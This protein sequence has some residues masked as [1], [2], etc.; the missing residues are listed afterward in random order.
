M[1]LLKNAD[2][3]LQTAAQR[4]RRPHVLRRSEDDVCGAPQSCA[5]LRSRPCGGASGLSALVAGEPSTRARPDRRARRGDLRARRGPHSARWANGWLRQLGTTSLTPGATVAAKIA[6]A[7]SFALP[8]IRA[9]GRRRHRPHRTPTGAAGRA[10]R[11]DACRHRV[12]RHPDRL[13]G[14]RRSHPG[15]GR[16]S[17][18]C[19]DVGAGAVGRVRLASCQRPLM[20]SWGRC[21]LFCCVRFGRGRRGRRRTGR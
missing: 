10:G 1:A 5:P 14:P 8:S 19:L 18:G 4:T 13:L 12:L 16:G 20:P 7:M 3:L 17:G 9:R 11:R 15:R 2:M 6:V 21:V